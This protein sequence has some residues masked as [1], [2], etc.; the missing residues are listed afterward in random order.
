LLI[1]VGGLKTIAMCDRDHDD[2]VFCQERIACRQG[3]KRKLIMFIVAPTLIRP[4]I[5]TNSRA[6]RIRNKTL[7]DS[8]QKSV[9]N[10]R[11][12]GLVRFSYKLSIFR[13]GGVVICGL[14]AVCV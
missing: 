7:L 10:R 5:P 2:A 4:E 6:L 11:A 14:E 12:S 9:V 3:I 1:A 8:L 13:I